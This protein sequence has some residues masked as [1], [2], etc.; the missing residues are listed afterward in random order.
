MQVGV[1]EICYNFCRHGRS[2]FGNKISF[3]KWP[4]NSLSDH[5]LLWFMFVK[6]FDQLES[7]QKIMQIGVDAKCMHTNFDGFC[8]SSFGDKISF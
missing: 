3:Q 5:G 6:K 7:A 8:L 2:G 1:D 4:K